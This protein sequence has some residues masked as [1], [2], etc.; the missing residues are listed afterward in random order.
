MIGAV[1]RLFVAVWPTAPALD[2]VR[3]LPRDGWVNVR[4]TPEDNWHVTLA[5][6]GEAE[7]DEVA[8]RLDGGEYPK[9][10]TELEARM[11]VMGR[12]S[13]VIPANG[14]DA[15][16]DAVR[17]LVFNELPQQR[18]L[19]HLTVGRS[20]GRRPISGRSPAGH[21]PESL[22]FDVDEVAL[23]RSTL[24]PQGARYDTVGTFACR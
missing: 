15:L 21:L 20:I 4:W 7:I 1:T 16:A 5:F 3:S 9:V 12:N 10:T 17:A 23:V 24:S 8:D 14:C 18:F 22:A 13:L 19:G 2:H 11:R 6:L